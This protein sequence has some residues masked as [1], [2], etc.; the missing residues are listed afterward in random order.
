MVS[1]WNN[2]DEK[3][4]QGQC[5]KQPTGRLTNSAWKYIHSEEIE[6]FRYKLISFF[7]GIAHVSTSGRAA[8][9]VYLNECTCICIEF[10]DRHLLCCHSMSVCKDQVLEPEE[11]TSSIYTVENYCNIYSESFALDPIRVKG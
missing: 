10:Q 7:E 5:K 6:A 2:L 11:F 9:F 8:H 3:Y 4:Y 1:I